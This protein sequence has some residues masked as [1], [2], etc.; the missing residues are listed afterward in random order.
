M[1]KRA[2]RFIHLP[3]MRDGIEMAELRGVYTV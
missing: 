3:V 2:K 1:G